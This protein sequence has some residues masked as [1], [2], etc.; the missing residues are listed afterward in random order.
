MGP[1]FAFCGTGVKSFFTS[2]LHRGGMPRRSGPGR[3]RRRGVSAQSVFGVR[4]IVTGFA[5]APDAV[6]MYLRV[7]EHGGIRSGFRLVVAGLLGRIAR[8]LGLDFD[9]PADAVE[10]DILGH[11]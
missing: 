11:V 3:A 6:G 1:V 8:R 9:L 10:L 5:G 4:S 7:L 2:F